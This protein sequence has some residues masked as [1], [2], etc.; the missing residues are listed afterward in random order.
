MIGSEYLAWFDPNEYRLVIDLH[1]LEIRQGSESS[2]SV[3]DDN[4]V[5][6]LNLLAQLKVTWSRWQT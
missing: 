6:I 2:L 5:R 1:N 4:H 3:E